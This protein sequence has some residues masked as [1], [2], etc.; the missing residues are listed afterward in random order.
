MNAKSKPKST[1]TRPD[2]LLWTMPEVAEAT[3]LCRAKLYQLVRDGAF[4]MPRRIS[5]GR[6]AWL[7]REIEAWA[8]ATPISVDPVRPS[9]RLR[10]TRSGD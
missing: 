5:K 8:E 2:R 1:A 6:I 10:V 7:P 4:P 9:P 3:G